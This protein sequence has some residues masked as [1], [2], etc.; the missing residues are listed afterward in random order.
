MLG[1]KL[2]TFLSLMMFDHHQYKEEIFNTTYLSQLVRL[3]MRLLNYHSSRLQKARQPFITQKNSSRCFREAQSNRTSHSPSP[4]FCVF[5][6]W[7]SNGRQRP[8]THSLSV[9]WHHLFLPN[10]WLRT[11]CCHLTW[12]SEKTLGCDFW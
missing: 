4:V 12:F 6:N 3:E 10:T 7:L 9:T 8:Q 11:L 5:H 2:L 1:Y